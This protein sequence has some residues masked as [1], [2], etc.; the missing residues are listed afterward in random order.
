MTVTSEPFTKENRMTVTY[1]KNVDFLWQVHSYQNEYIRF[2]DTK[3]ALCI[4]WSTALISALYSAEIHRESGTSNVYLATSVLAASVLLAGFLLGILAIVPR[5]RLPR[6]NAKIKADEATKVREQ[7][8]GLIYWGEVQRLA[9]VSQYEQA[10]SDA[11]ASDLANQVAR[12]V[13]V[14]SKIA[15]VKYRF[16]NLSIAALA[17]GSLLTVVVLVL[18]S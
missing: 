4:A 15:I 18:K 5:V 17:C 11:D 8:T 6:H 9:D 12:H 7:K 14:L 1:N 16:V 2:A 10:V 13:F 3:A